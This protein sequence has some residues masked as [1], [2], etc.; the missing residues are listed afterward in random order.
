LGTPPGYGHAV[1]V[2]YLLQTILWYRDDTV[3]ENNNLTFQHRTN[4]NIL[5][6]KWNTPEKA[7]L[8]LLLAIILPFLALVV[9]VFL[10]FRK[11]TL[12]LAKVIQEAADTVPEIDLENMGLSDS[13]KDICELLLTNSNLKEIA[14]ILGLTYAG[15]HKKARKLYAKLGIQNRTELLVR[16]K[17]GE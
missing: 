8:R 2:A 7:L 11:R 17:K 4:G 12:K 14:A 1:A 13:E 9:Y 6:G 16:V 15:G 3:K 5:I 10:I